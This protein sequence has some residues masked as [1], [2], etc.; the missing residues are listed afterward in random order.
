M[1]LSFLFILFSPSCRVPQS[2]VFSNDC[3]VPCW[4]N[5]EPGI[6][7]MEGAIAII[8]T[9]ADVEKETIG[10]T[11]MEKPIVSD[12]IYFSLKTGEETT[13][14]FGDNIVLMI[15][16]YRS[17]GMVSI[18]DCIDEFGGPDFVI[19]TNHYGPGG[20][21]FIPSSAWHT[22]FHAL[23]PK[24]GFLLSYDTFNQEPNLS[25][26]TK[27]TGVKYFD[28]QSFSVLYENNFLVYDE[29]DAVV[30]PE[31]FLPWKGY[32]KISFLYPEN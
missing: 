10:T 5:I 19:L 12:K 31:N 22:W 20:V 21:P 18:G 28:P 17:K 30:A 2:P 16:F 15:S 6:T 29:W 7:T 26:N 13:I 25:P 9:M 14:Y 1:Q 23:S 8:A 32:G 24:K 11:R 27:V 4:R 3:S